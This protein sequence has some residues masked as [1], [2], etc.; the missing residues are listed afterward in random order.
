MVTLIPKRARINDVLSLRAAIEA[1][2]EDLIRAIHQLGDIE[3]RCAQVRLAVGTA[4]A[5]M[6]SVVA[7]Y[8]RLVVEYQPTSGRAG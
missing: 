2:R 5:H 6:E 7:I 1:G 4:E 3:R 8:N